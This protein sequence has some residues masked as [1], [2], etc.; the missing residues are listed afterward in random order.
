MK[1][2]EDRE[3]DRRFG[4]MQWRMLIATMVGYTLFYFMRKNFSFAMPGLQQD[5]GISKPMLGNFLF[6]G[7][8]VYGISKFVN[9]IVGDKAPAD[10]MR[11]VPYAHLRRQFLRRNPE[12]D[13]LCARREACSLKKLAEDEKDSESPRERRSRTRQARRSSLRKQ[14]RYLRS[15]AERHV[16]EHA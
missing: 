5:C 4:R 1:L 2:F 16:H 11:G 9:G 6:W 7:G 10:G 15:E 12:R 8:I 13:E 14:R 3:T